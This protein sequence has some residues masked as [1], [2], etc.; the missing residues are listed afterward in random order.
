MMF[1]VIVVVRLIVKFVVSSSL[2]DGVMVVSSSVMISVVVLVM[3]M[4]CWLKWLLSGV[5]SRMLSV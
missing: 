2:S 4:W 1:C 5:S 3:I